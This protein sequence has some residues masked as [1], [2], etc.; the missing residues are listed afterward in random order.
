MNYNDVN[1]FFSSYDDFLLVFGHPSFGWCG[2][3]C[4]LPDTNPTN[5]L[6]RPGTKTS[7]KDRLESDLDGNL[8]RLLIKKQETWYSVDATINY[9]PLIDKSKGECLRIIRE[10]QSS[11]RMKRIWVNLSKV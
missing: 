7:P 9:E 6:T 2:R 11:S 3:F 10:V 8:D 1:F 4:A 5:R